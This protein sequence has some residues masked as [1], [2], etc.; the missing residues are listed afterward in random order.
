MDEK[1][2][3]LAE[4][5]KKETKSEIDE[6]KPIEIQNPFVCEQNLTEF[7]SEYEKYK[8]S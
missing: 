4:E 5:S 8:V 7:H 6:L 2:E 3:K 1:D